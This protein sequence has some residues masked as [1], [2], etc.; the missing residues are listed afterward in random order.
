MQII[1]LLFYTFLEYSCM[2]R[3]LYIFVV[4]LLSSCT[5]QSQI[6]DGVVHIT[7]LHDG[8]EVVR[9]MWVC[10]DQSTILT[11][12]HVVRDD[13]LRYEVWGMRYEVSERDTLTDRAYL[14]VMSEGLGVKNICRDY[15]EYIWKSDI[16]S[17]E[18]VSIPVVRSGSLVIL[19]GTINSLT[20][21]LL[22]YDTLGRTQVLSGIIMTDISLVPWDSGAPILDEEGRVVDVV[23]VQ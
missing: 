16:V 9:G 7:W 20:G 2:N 12:A 10:V 18:S 1:A 8:I 4:S 22:A 23:H 14:T 17:W 5:I 6:T 19:T 15:K 21:T 3:Y 11:S 13:A